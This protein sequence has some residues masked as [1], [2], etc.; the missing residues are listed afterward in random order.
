MIRPW[1]IYVTQGRPGYGGLALDREAAFVLDGR[2]LTRRRA[3]RAADRWKA[4]Y[5]KRR[6]NRSGMVVVVDVVHQRELAS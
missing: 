4:D 6:P 5:E 3:W 2:Y 1:R